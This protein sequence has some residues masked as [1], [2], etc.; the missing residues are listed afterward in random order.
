MEI[1]QPFFID[2][3]Q[4]GFV[5]GGPFDEMGGMLVGMHAKEVCDMLNEHPTLL[6]EGERLREV[7]RYSRTT[8]FCGDGCPG[9]YQCWYVGDDGEPTDLVSGI[10]GT[11]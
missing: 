3:T 4:P 9:C 7:I 8:N 5:R 10:Q 2:Q 6:T 11:G 1:K